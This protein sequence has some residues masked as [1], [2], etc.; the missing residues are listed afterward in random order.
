LDNLVPKHTFGNP[1][2]CKCIACRH[3]AICCC[4]WL[5]LLSASSSSSSSS[6]S[7]LIPPPQLHTYCHSV[8]L[9]LS[10]FLCLPLL[11]DLAFLFHVGTFFV[12]EIPFVM[13][14]YQT[15]DD[16]QLTIQLWRFG[17]LFSF[18]FRQKEN[19]CNSK[20]FINLDDTR[21]Y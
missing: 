7:Y 5:L 3:F 19:N 21:V 17:R 14:I 13:F 1:E 11:D 20:P 10:L 15:G 6:S 18:A 9:S 2:S 8:S 4:H 16:E 12:F